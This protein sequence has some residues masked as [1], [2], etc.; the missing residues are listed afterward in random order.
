MKNSR[1]GIPKGKHAGIISWKVI[2]NSL[3]I[4]DFGRC[5]PLIF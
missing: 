4:S 3:I 1:E 5:N 2:K